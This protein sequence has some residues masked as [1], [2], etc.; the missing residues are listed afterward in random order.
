MDWFTSVLDNVTIGCMLAG[1]SVKYGQQKA[2]NALDL[3]GLEH[4]YDKAVDELSGGQQQRVQIAR[5]IAH[6]PKYFVLDEPTTGL[7]LQ[8]SESLMEHIAREVA[9]N[10]GAALISSH[11]FGLLGRYCNKLLF[12]FGGEVKHFGS[13]DQTIRDR[14]LS[15]LSEQECQA[16]QETQEEGGG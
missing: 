9:E 8:S 6:Q 2:K 3:L 7:D 4:Y 10:D 14:Y 16:D 12:I 11:D 5:A 15:Y 1:A 13:I